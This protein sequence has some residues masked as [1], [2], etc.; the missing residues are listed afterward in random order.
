MRFSLKK[1]WDFLWKS[2]SIWS[3]IAS[4]ILAFL[5]VKYLVYPGLGLILG[6]GYPI[7]AVVS[8]SMEHNG[9]DLDEWWEL[10]GDWYERN[11]ISLEEFRNFK[12]KDGFN[13]GDIMVLVGE[14]PQNINIGDILVF[15]SNLDNPVIH[16]VIKKWE[17]SRM[18]HFQTKGDNN[19]DSGSALGEL[20]ISEDRIVGKAVFR[21][22][23]L[24]WLKII[25]SSLLR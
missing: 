2:D 13:K 16:R 9:L 24:G 10:N 7:V 14:N 21:I 3:W 11:N 5:I 23:Y 4:F 25:F 15:E 1:I 18:Y 17:E 20:D 8:G 6:T 22:P 19:R 12:F